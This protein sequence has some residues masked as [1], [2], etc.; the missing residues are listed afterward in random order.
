MR[1]SLKVEMESAHN[2]TLHA[3]VSLGL[4]NASYIKIVACVQ[5]DLLYTGIRCYMT[6]Q[7][8]TINGYLW[9]SMAMEKWGKDLVV[10]WN[11]MVVCICWGEVVIPKFYLGFV[12]KPTSSMHEH[13]RSHLIELIPLGGN[14]MFQKLYSVETKHIFIHVNLHHFLSF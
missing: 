13:W 12:F 7:I 3:C 9:W 10:M 14:D 8:Q 1:K 4:C 2:T 6:K 5:R 11:W